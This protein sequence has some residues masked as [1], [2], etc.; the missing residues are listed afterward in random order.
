[1]V[2]LSLEYIPSQRGTFLRNIVPSPRK[3]KTHHRGFCFVFFNMETI[4]N[5]PLQQLVPISDDDMT[6]ITDIDD[7]D[8][9]IQKLSS[10]STS[11]QTKSILELERDTDRILDDIRNIGSD[12]NTL[13]KNHPSTNR[14]NKNIYC[15]VRSKSSKQQEGSKGCDGRSE[16]HL[17]EHTIDID[18]DDDEDDDSIVGELQRLE[19]V[20]A[21]IRLSLI[22]T[23]NEAS[24]Y[25]FCSPT[26][27]GGKST[28]TTTTTITT[29]TT[30]NTSVGP[31]L[32][33]CLVIR[34]TKEYNDILQRS[35]P[36]SIW[37][38]VVIWI[39]VW[40][41][42]STFSTSTSLWSINEQGILTVCV[43]KF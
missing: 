21:T 40:Y 16:N 10:S 4:R 18:N 14:K 25:A 6:L 8:S 1:M 5:Q 36:I 12:H 41:G 32:D 29:T 31:E 19:S 15:S 38:M 3:I 37:T 33:Q 7:D 34:T 17:T 11:F 24:L 13:P 26:H 23:T 28:T 9:Y 2:G 27:H 20:T 35:L 42:W 30:T 39:G 43:P 22:D